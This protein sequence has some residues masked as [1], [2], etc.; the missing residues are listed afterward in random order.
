MGASRNASA[1]VAEAQPQPITQEAAGWERARAPE[2]NLE[3]IHEEPDDGQLML[4]E[5][6]RAGLYYSDGDET[7]AEGDGTRYR[8][9]MER[10][11][12]L[13]FGHDWYLFT[14]YYQL[15]ATPEETQNES[16]DASGASLDRP[17]PD[18]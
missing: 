5:E 18:L 8:L 17:P 16:G 10:D 7:N 6:D 14:P 13:R 1:T 2:V 9:E 4:S 3:V 15:A 12:E 11:M